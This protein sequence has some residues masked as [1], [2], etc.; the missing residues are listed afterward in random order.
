MKTSV[1]LIRGTR[2]DGSFYY[3]YEVDGKYNPTNGMNLI[4]TINHV[5]KH[6]TNIEFVQRWRIEK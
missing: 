1:Y 3:A 6:Y 4:Q 5:I 2:P